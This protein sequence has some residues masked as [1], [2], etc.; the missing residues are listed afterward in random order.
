MRKLIGSSL[1]FRWHACCK[2]ARPQTEPTQDC[3]RLKV[4]ATVNVKL[5][6]KVCRGN[7]VDLAIAAK[8]PTVLWTAYRGAERHSKVSEHYSMQIR[9]L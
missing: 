4:G 9:L 7:E 3:L 1:E 6:S 2:Q 5:A 8:A